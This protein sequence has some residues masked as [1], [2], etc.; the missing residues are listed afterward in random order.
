MDAKHENFWTIYSFNDPNLIRPSC[1][2]MFY[3]K[4]LFYYVFTKTVFLY[5]TGITDTH[6]R[7]V[8]FF[9]NTCYSLSC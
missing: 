4:L 2:Y 3:F 8:H 5:L 9:S 7:Q 6:T 1:V